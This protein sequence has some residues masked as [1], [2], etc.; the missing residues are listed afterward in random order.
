MQSGEWTI[1]DYGE[2]TELSP[3]VLRKRNT[4]SGSGGASSGDGARGDGAGVSGTAS[5][6][7]RIVRK[8]ARDLAPSLRTDETAHWAGLWTL[9][10]CVDRSKESLRDQHNSIEF[11]RGPVGRVVVGDEE[12]EE[13]LDNQHTSFGRDDDSSDSSD[14]G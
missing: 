13:D 4:S 6:L 1:L 7:T 10:S 12:Y 11:Y 2:L 8:M 5:E 14:F 9:D 3:S